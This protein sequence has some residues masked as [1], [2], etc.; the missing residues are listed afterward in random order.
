MK[1]LITLLTMMWMLPINGQIIHITD[2]D[3]TGGQTYHWT[4]D[5]VY[6]LDGLVF[7]E[8]GG[9]LYIEAG[10]VLKFT[11]RADVGN[12]S[13]LIITPGAQIFAEGTQDEPIIF[14]AEI[15]DL[16]DPY[17]LGPTDNSLWGGLAILGN[18]ITQK[19]GNAIANLEGI[20]TSEPRAQYGGTNN[21]DNSGILTYVSIR[22]GGR[23]IVSGSELNGLT[24]AAVGSG[25]ILD[26]IEVYANSDDGIEFF[27]GA[28]NLKH[29]VVAF[30][31]DDSFDWDE[32]YTGK[33]QFWFSI[34]REDIADTGGE[35]DGSTPDD[36]SPSSDPIVY[37]WTH[38][39]SGPG[40]SASNPVG[41]L[42]RAGT[43]GIVA[44]SIITEMKNK[45]IEVQDKDAG[46]NDAYAKLISGEL[47]IKSNIF[48]RN[49]VNTTIDGSPNGIIRITSNQPNQDDPDASFLADHLTSFGSVIAD[50]LIH[51]VSR[52]Q[53]ATLDPRPGIEGAAYTN[54]LHSIPD[55]DPFFKEVNYAGAFSA[56]A[57]EFWLK[58]WT[59][60]A[61]NGHLKDLTTSTDIPVPGTWNFEMYPNPVTGNQVLTILPH[62]EDDYVVQLVSI[63]GRIINS[64]SV[65]SSITISLNTGK[66]S[67]G[68]YT[69]RV[70]GSKGN[71][72]TK[73]LQVQ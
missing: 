11:P 73:L 66:L 28:P 29:A 27:G 57:N 12:P 53:D 22:H 17:D 30:A 19:N 47:E 56:D 63:D 59:T 18:G 72:C 43:A 1:L 38:I 33:G 14:T 39:G 5:H 71:S 10:T 46:A 23:Q 34:Q 65:E 9:K 60:L 3:L 68:L 16:D 70:L 50:P 4:K 62:V 35:L 24:L 37:N 54:T 69:L 49:G 6:L 51:S 48:W 36:L 64:F 13:A 25:T 40:A 32:V 8:A 15:D 20:D 44:N 21:D 26:H 7:L 31:E 45:A 41:L 52:I 58:D 2:D 42:F 67:P 61:R 55:G